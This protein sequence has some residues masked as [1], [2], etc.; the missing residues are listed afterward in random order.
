MNLIFTE[1]N[2]K[3]ITNNSKESL[4][5]YLETM[6]QIVN[7][8]KLG[9]TQEIKKNNKDSLTKLCNCFKN[10]REQLKDDLMDLLTIKKLKKD[11]EEFVKS[12][13]EKK[14]EKYKKEI[15]YK[16]FC[17]KDIS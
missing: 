12:V 11:N 5:K 4:E 14:S 10:V 7:N 6:L 1:Y 13:Y 9:L 16:K 15:S 8:E 17:G 2:I 3:K